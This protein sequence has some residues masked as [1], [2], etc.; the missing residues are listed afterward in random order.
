MSGPG[1][2]GLSLKTLLELE[3]K[4]KLATKLAALLPKGTN[5]QEAALGFAHA[6]QLAAAAHASK[7]LDLPFVLLKFTMKDSSSKALRGA[8]AE[9]RPIQ[10][11]GAEVK[12][13]E[14]QAKDD[15]KQ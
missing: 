1:W 2:S 6:R 9:L 11:A 3:S 5:L 14:Q 15:M 7:N 4:P 13:A 10:D 8:I 12:K